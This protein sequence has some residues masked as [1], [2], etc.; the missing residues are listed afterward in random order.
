MPAATPG[1]SAFAITRKW[2]ARHPDRLQL[3]SLPPPNGVKVSVMLE[4]VGLPCEPHT[5]HF[6]TGDQHS[7]A[8][9]SL[10]PNHKIPALLDPDGPGGAPMAL[11]ESGAILVYLAE[12]TGQ[13]LPASGAARRATRPC[14]G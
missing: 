3:Y 14:S 13:L 4:E 6:D 1:L 9:L 8:F 7:P 2:P 5:V 11:F 10:N 12:K